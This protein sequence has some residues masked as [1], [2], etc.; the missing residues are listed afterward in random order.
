MK[1]TSISQWESGVHLKGERVA[2][3]ILISMDELKRVSQQLRCIATTHERSNAPAVTDDAKIRMYRVTFGGKTVVTPFWE[4]VIDI[5]T[6]EFKDDLAA[7]AQDE[8]SISVTQ[9]SAQE[10]DNTSDFEG[11]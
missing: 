5:L 11:W 2:G 1:K 6:D 9:M 8:V 4:M 3:G 10:Y 7:D